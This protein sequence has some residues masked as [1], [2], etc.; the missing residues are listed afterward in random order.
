MANIQGG[1]KRRVK[2][3]N[4]PMLTN[5]KIQFIQ[6]YI[7]TL[8]A[9]ESAKLSGYSV[10]TAYSQGGRLLKSVEVKKAIDE[11]LAKKCAES[12]LTKKSLLT[13]LSDIINSPDSKP[14]EITRAI[15][16]ASKIM[17]INKE[18]HT[19]VSLFQRIQQDIDEDKEAPY[20][21]QRQGYIEGEDDEPSK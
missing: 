1:E 17:G 15:E 20:I 12:K 10:K 7:K 19:Q 2:E 18:T 16:V 13:K 9:T 21:P 8:N 4:I 3:S 5:R 11:G 6:Y 14:H